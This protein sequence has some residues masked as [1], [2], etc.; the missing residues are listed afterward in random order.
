MQHDKGGK[1][2][3]SNFEILR[4]AV[5]QVE[6]QL[7][8]DKIT[9]E[10]AVFGLFFSGV[11]LS[12]GHGGLC[13]TPVKE[14][15]EAVCCPSS[16]RAMPLS[17]RLRGRPVREYLD[18]I[19]GENILRRT[20]GIAALNAL[21]VAA[22]EQS[23]PQ[24]YEIL[25]GVDAFDELDAARYPKTVVVGALVPMLKKLMAAGADFHVLE[26]DPRTLKG[27]E[28][29]YHLLPEAFFACGVTMLGGIQVTKPDELLN[30][31][32]E[33]GSGYHLFGRYAE[34]TAIRKKR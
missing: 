22:W 16:A 13:F 28:M 20:L 7:E 30:I 31:I 1:P 19:F 3:W 9:V 5:A 6:Q 11:K 4:E 2:T 33:G 17:G 27:R 26:Q 12:T 10:R 29:P 34:W 18:D 23:P 8:L 24:D 25:M 14:M 15:P 32:S 21:S